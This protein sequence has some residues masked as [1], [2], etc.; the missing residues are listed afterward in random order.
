MGAVPAGAVSAV[1][2]AGVGWVGVAAVAVAGYAGITDEVVAGE[3]VGVEVTVIGDARVQHRHH[4]AGA[5]GLVPGLV[6]ADA[7]G[8]FEVVPLVAVVVGV[9]RRQR[10]VHLLVDLDVFHRRVGGQALHQRFGVRAAKLAR[11]PEHLG[12]GGG[13][14]HLLQSERPAMQGRCGR[15]LQRAVQGGGIVSLGAALAVLH[16]EAVIALGLLQAGRIDHRQV[17]GEGA[18]SR[19]RKDGGSGGGERP[20]AQWTALGWGHVQYQGKW[21]EPRASGVQLTFCVKNFSREINFF[22]FAHE[23]VMVITNS[24]GV[25]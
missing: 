17:G 18:G 14:A 20:A 21:D 2:V 19:Q 5:V 8:G 13:A 10:R 4:H 12:A 3:D 25:A 11:G 24:M 6:G 23:S 15:G 22:S 7:A 16:D 9:V 1:V